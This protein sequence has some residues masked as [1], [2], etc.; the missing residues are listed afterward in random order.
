MNKEKI[1][2]TQM[3]IERYTEII[4]P[5]IKS[6][7]EEQIEN[8]GYFKS[9]FIWYL[10]RQSFYGYSIY[11][12][13]PISK[14]ILEEYEKRNKRRDIKE[15]ILNNRGLPGNF[16]QEHIYTGT[17]FRDDLKTL[18]EDRKFNVKNIIQVVKENFALGWYKKTEIKNFPKSK[19][20]KEVIEKMKAM[21]TKIN[22]PQ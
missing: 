12:D 14:G 16:I 1:L 9:N 10:Y 22:G 15:F 5:L 17:M 3:P 6:N 21:L 4:L 2:H 8:E 13:R 20:S 19:R 7:I 18:Y 11:F